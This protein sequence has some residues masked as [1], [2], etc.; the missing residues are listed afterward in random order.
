MIRCSRPLTTYPAR[1]NRSNR[2]F[3]ASSVAVDDD[4]WS[5]IGPLLTGR[6]SAG[7]GLSHRGAGHYGAVGDGLHRDAPVA[8]LRVR[9][10][11]GSCASTG[12]H[13]DNQCIWPNG[14]W[15]TMTLAGVDRACPARRLRPR[16]SSAT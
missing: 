15:H 11:L 5:S 2:L 1:A 8:A 16:S 6:M 9:A 3:W 13:L 14:D 7:E 4:A 12:I 10:E